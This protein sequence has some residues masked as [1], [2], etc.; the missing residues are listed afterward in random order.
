MPLAI[1]Q[2]TRRPARLYDI[3]LVLQIRAKEPKQGICAR[4]VV[5]RALG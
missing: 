5:D 1:A 2:I 4:R 3:R